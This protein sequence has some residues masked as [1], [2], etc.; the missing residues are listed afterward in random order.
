[1]QYAGLDWASKGWFGFVLDDS[2][3]WDAGFCPT[4][5]NF[6]H[7]TDDVA[8][9]L[10]DIPIGLEK[11]GPRACDEQAR[12]YLGPDGRS[13]FNTPVRAAV[14]AEN[15]EAAKR[16]HEERDVDFGIQNQAWGIVPRIREVDVFLQHYGYRLDDVE[17]CESHPEVCFQAHNG[18][19]PLTDGKQTEAG[20]AQRRSLLAE[21]FD[22]VDAII[23]EIEERF[24]QPSYAPVISSNG[25]DDVL[26]AMVL[27][28]TA[29]EKELV[30]LPEDPPP[31]FVLGG[32]PIEIVR[33]PER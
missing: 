5:L 2:G 9:V 7:E 14:E 16:V 31:D 25:M 32:R 22:D 26:D 4:V 17:F 6:H 21:A 29:S 19:T 3:E 11:R 15:I 18:G 23:A 1:M 24:M 12:A 30:Q 8:C 10:V 13:V 20:L 33:P 28:V 27:A